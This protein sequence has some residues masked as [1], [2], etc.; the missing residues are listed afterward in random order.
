[1]PDFN[2]GF[3]IFPDLTQFDFTGPL[4][5]LTRLPQAATHII[6]KSDAPVPSD[7]GLGLVPTRTFANC[8]PLDLILHSRRR[9]RSIGGIP[10]GRRRMS[11]RPCPAA[12]RRPDRLFMPPSRKQLRDRQ[13]IWVLPRNAAHVWRKFRDKCARTDMMTWLV[14]TTSLRFRMTEIVLLSDPSFR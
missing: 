9:R 1:M 14:S 10:T 12:T 13:L 7:C 5:V 3:V 6:A 4:Q 2:V 8:P 11:C